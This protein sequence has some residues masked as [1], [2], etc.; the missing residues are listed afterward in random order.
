MSLIS[1]RILRPALLTAILLSG[2]ASSVSAQAGPG[3][4]WTP[5]VNLSEG[6]GV[7]CSYSS[8][9]AVDGSGTVHV[10]WG[11]CLDSVPESPAR[12][13]YYRYL[14]DGTWS[15]PVDIMTTPAGG[16]I[17]SSVVQATADGRLH[18]V[19]VRLAG[20]VYETYYSWAPI[21][22]AAS[23]RA[24]A[25]PKLVSSS[26]RVVD[27]K[28]TD[29]GAL[30]VVYTSADRA[31]AYLATSRDLGRTWSQVRIQPQAADAVRLAVGERDTLHLVLQHDDN[32]E[33]TLGTILY[34]RTMDDGASWSN[35]FIVDRKSVG[36]SR[37][38]E[39]YRPSFPV[40]IAV[41][42]EQVH[43]VWL[44][45]PNNQRWHA[46]SADGGRT[47][48]SPVQIDPLLRARNGYTP[49]VADSRGTIHLF[50]P[51]HDWSKE[52]VG[53]I[54]YA[55]WDL[56]RQQ[57]MPP[58][59][60]DTQYEYDYHMANM[61]ISG[62]NTLYAVLE[63]HRDNLITGAQAFDIWFM[64]GDVPVPGVPLRQIP[65]VAAS[66][67]ATHVTISTPAPTPTPPHDPPAPLGGLA[68]DRAQGSGASPAAVG[69][70]AAVLCL[71]LVMAA[72]VR[73]HR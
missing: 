38:S 35:P 44:G 53:G 7:Q 14:K 9:I 55:W 70:G 62:G 8:S 28:A 52:G 16:T 2:L 57:W 33:G 48:S 10:V 5:K 60:I 18:V 6:L 3:A 73:K 64:R 25:A 42:Q 30:R 72:A 37:Y 59:L 40:I 45:S 68:P 24:W 29:D 49:I 17:E 41:G 1:R 31:G 56:G 61:V 21:G 46:W 13:I 54:W 71:A 15:A 51:G 20:Y 19:W 47:W 23:A 36:D 27:F 26:T 22:K 4:T 69:L 34:L 32:P 43:I 66:S 65:T 67:T 12:S 39:T 63:D 50:S 11:E 58:R